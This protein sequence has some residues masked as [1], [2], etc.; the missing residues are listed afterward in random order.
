MVAV[1]SQ[2]D[3][4]PLPRSAELPITRARSGALPPSFQL[5]TGRAELRSSTDALASASYRYRHV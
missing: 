2:D 4:H 3:V 1:S 5:E